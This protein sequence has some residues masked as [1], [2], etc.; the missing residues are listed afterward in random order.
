MQRKWLLFFLTGLCMSCRANVDVPG[1]DHLVK[2][3]DYREWVYIGTELT[4]NDLNDGAATFPEFH[5]VYINPKG[6]R[7]WKT[8]GEFVD[9]TIIVKELLSVG[10]HQ[11]ITGKGYF[12]GEY[13]GVLGVAVKNKKR[14]TTEPGN[15]GYFVFDNS[16]NT[17]PR[18]LRQNTNSCATCHLTHAATDSVF[19]QYYPVLRAAKPLPKNHEPSVGI[20]KN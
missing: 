17:N 12:Q 8:N 15:W 7:A 16:S 20:D 5:N 19:S 3:K 1:A 11:A 18:A 2:P 9:G 13:T 14:F 6:W 10:A 4:P